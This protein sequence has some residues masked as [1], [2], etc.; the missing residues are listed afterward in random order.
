MTISRQR[1]GRNRLESFLR[2]TTT[3]VTRDSSKGEGDGE[4]KIDKR[5]RR[6][7][8]ELTS[9]RQLAERREEAG[10][11]SLLHLAC[12]PPYPHPFFQRRREETE[13]GGARRGRRGGYE[14]EIMQIYARAPERT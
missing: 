7:K 12:P 5:T 1:P 3:T 4:R 9:A 11:L 8:E 10:L 13:E 6:T 14:I 2:L